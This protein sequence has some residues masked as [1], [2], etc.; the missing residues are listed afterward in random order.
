MENR[1]QSQR[2]GTRQ[3]PKQTSHFELVS[4]GKA[5][6]QPASHPKKADGIETSLPIKTAPSGK[7]GQ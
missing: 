5:T 2:Q 7:I 6:W 3:Q 4:K 1:R